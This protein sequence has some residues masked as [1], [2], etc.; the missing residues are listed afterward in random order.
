MQPVFPYQRFYRM[1]GLRLPSQ[2]L[3]PVMAP[4]NQIILPQNAAIHYVNLDPE[5][6]TIDPN[7]PLLAHNQATVGIEHVQAYPDGIELGNPRIHPV[8]AHVVLDWNSHHKKFRNLKMMPTLVRNNKALIIESYTLLARKYTYSKNF[9]HDF[10]IWWNTFSTVWN[11]VRHL[12]E[13]CD[14]QQFLVFHVP[15]LLPSMQQLNLHANRISQQTLHRF[16]T[17]ALRFIGEI[18]QWLGPDRDK[19]FGD[20]K[21]FIPHQAETDEEKIVYSNLS[22][23]PLVHIDFL[24]Q[25]DDTVLSKLNI[26]WVHAGMWT[27]M[28]LGV[29]NSWRE[30][31]SGTTPKM[32]GDKKIRPDQLQKRFLRYLMAISETTSVTVSQGETDEVDEQPAPETVSETEGEDKPP[33]TSQE[34]ELQRLAEHAEVTPVE[35]KTGVV[36]KQSKLSMVKIISK[37]SIAGEKENDRD[38]EN[39][40]VPEVNDEDIDADLKKLEVVNAVAKANNFETTYKTYTP[41]PTSLEAGVNDLATEMAAK[42]LISP[43]EMK[44]LQKLSEKYKKIPNPFTNEGKLEDLLTITHEELVIPEKNN[45]VDDLPGVVDKSML[46]SSLARFDETYVKKLMPKHIAKTVMSLQKSGVAIQDYSIQTVENI[47]DSFDVHTVRLVPVVGK[48]T[49][50]R[51]QLPKVSREGIFKAAGV[52][53]RMR[54]QKASL[55][56][57]KTAPNAVTLTSYY[58]KLFVKRADRSTFNYS[59]WLGDNI[60]SMSMDE[61]SVLKDVKLADVSYS[62]IVVPRVYSIISQ[63]CKSFRVG[64]FNFFFDFAERSKFFGDKT[65]KLYDTYGFDNESKVDNYYIVIGATEDGSEAFCMRPD[66]LVEHFPVIPEKHKAFPIEVIFGLENASRPYDMVEVEVFGQTVPLGFLLAYHVGL[67]N[68]LE[69]LKPTYRRAKKGGNYD[70]KVGEFPVKFQDEVLIFSTSTLR[71]QML[72]LIFSGLNRYHRDIKNYSVYAFDKQDAFANVLEDNGVGARYLRE[73]DLLFTMWVDHITEELLRRMELPTDL[74]NLFIK[75]CEELVNDKHHD[76]TD[77]EV[78][79]IRGYERFSGLLYGELIRGLR[80][81]NSKPKNANAQVTI[82]PEA[83]WM[84]IL[85]DQTVMPIEEMNP[86][87]SLKEME[88]VTYTGAQGRSGRTMVAKSRTMHRNAMG[89]VSEA[90]VDNADVATAIY[91]PP[92]PVLDSMLGTSKRLDKLEGNA[93]RLV[94]TS[95]LLAPGA[96]TDDPKRA[97]FISIQ[98]SQ[99]THCLAST[100]LPCRTGYERVLIHRVGDLYGRVAEQDG[101]ITGLTENVI[102][103]TYKDGSVD[104]VQ[105]GRIFGMQAGHIIPHYLSTD[106]KLGSK[107]KKGMTIAY[108]NNYFQRDKLD[109]NQVIYKAGVMAL[110]AQMETNDTHEDSS[111]ISEDLAKKLHT[112][113]TH[114]RNIKVSFDQEI[115][116]LLSV[117]TT[118][119]PESILCTIHNATAGNAEIFSPEALNT[120]S[121]VS[122][123]TPT[124]KTGGVIEKIEVLYAG[125]TDDMSTSLRKLAESSDDRQRNLN[126]RL[127]KRASDGLVEIGYRVDGHPMEADSAVIRVYITGPTGMGG[128]DKVVFGNQLKSVVARVMTGENTDAHGRPLDAL[129][130]RGAIDRRITPSADLIGTTSTLLIALGE[131][132]VKA[133]DEA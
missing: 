24:S 115:H 23:N 21:H 53:Y 55:P 59:K 63:R 133:Y 6:V 74:F 128:G 28:N 121:V 86:I 38:D 49:T 127:G 70:L 92:D 108:N 98:N 99:S 64:K 22:H 84:S 51:F 32:P 43:S 41:P 123:S 125:E 101:E 113:T 25:L 46:S 122:S 8:P 76:E 111:A 95:F 10:N 97:N 100:P 57:A 77:E 50:I 66:G 16:D 4:L 132:F 96:H 112:L 39:D 40:D 34:L 103:I 81:Y 94:S 42:G 79:R 105:T 11:R 35:T 19:L 36:G 126:R 91:M 7:D 5:E 80:D 120:L 73:F 130:S 65:M 44:G 13:T 118:V 89:V 15:A 56:F 29:L 93:T 90:T 9:M 69:T 78:L 106:L 107:V 72:G 27:V 18:W 26:I 52:K 45:L 68:L 83:V 17:D 71:D 12:V 110:V 129:F 31:P 30:D 104:N 37:A 87:H 58:S 131:M 102:T 85:K 62:D 61:A 33:V 60:V 114:T 1:H 119:T 82:N 109:P 20:R 124:A 48:P 2:L 75:A 47:T 3:T 67:G 88:V 14:R 54:K 117:G 116:N